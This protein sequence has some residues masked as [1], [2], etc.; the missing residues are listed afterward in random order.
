[1]DSV[2]VSGD[3]ER[4]VVRDD[5]RMRVVPTAHKVGD[6]DSDDAVK[7]DLGRVRVSVDPR[8]EWRQM[9][10][11]DGRASCATTTGART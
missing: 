7:V 3:G 9:Y 2:R 11:E 1:M 8:A 10:D 4:L 5:G 6:D